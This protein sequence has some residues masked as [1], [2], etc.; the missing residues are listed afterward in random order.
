MEFL[1]QKSKVPRSFIE[2]FLFTV[3]KLSD[4][5]IENLFTAN[6]EPIYSRKRQFTRFHINRP[7]LIPQNIISF[8]IRKIVKNNQKNPENRGK[9]KNMNETRISF[10]MSRRI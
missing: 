4:T 8:N 6:R 7:H 10:Q 2:N 5:E 9:I 3:C 1:I